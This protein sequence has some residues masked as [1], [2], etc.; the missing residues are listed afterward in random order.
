MTT[1]QLL[2]V[3]V[4]MVAVLLVLALFAGAAIAYFVFRRLRGRR[5]QPRTAPPVAS[6]PAARVTSSAPAPHQNRPVDQPVPK[7]DV[8]R[9]DPRIA[10]LD[11]EPPSSTAAVFRN[12][13][14]VKPIL[15]HEVAES[16]RIGRI[17]PLAGGALR[18]TG[19][20]L[21]SFPTNRGGLD[22]SYADRLEAVTQ[23]GRIDAGM[24]WV[25]HWL[26]SHSE[27]AGRLDD[28]SFAELYP[29][30]DLPTVFSATPP[31]RAIE[32]GGDKYR[33]EQARWRLGSGGYHADR[34]LAGANVYTAAGE[35]V[36]DQA[37]GAHKAIGVWVPADKLQQIDDWN[38]LG[39]RSSGSASYELTGPVEVPRRWSFEITGDTGAHF[40]PFMGVMVGAAQH[41]VDLTLQFV[42]AKRKAG[43]TTG[44][45]D[46]T[47]L[48]DAMSSLDML[49]LGL[50]GYADYID[51]VRVERAGVFTVEEAAWIHTVGMPV[52]ETLMK[53][54]DI[55][56]D[57]VGT[58]YV[59]AGSEFGRVLRDI[60]VG[61]AHAWFRR[62]DALDLRTRH[63]SVV[64]DSPRF[65]PIWDAGWPVQL[66]AENVSAS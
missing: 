48:A 15:W 34:W 50:R 23:V 40:F 39:L 7:G 47:A 44:S 27:L 58:G 29:S 6:T 21:W 11:L 56:S 61:L 20:Y 26:S 24:A 57:I 64:L 36:I 51:R 49:A 18:A 32:I 55:T 53:V 65:T 9:D 33:I 16:D 5:R 2:T 14:K 37:T 25:V 54:R 17:T 19:V 22:A 35:A 3:L 12:L 42:R 38:P 10:A 60:Q 28:E 41:L 31:A 4:T 59:P 52:R 66:P 62:S 8:P 63:M 45:H 1:D 46:V 13:D 43:V 30:L